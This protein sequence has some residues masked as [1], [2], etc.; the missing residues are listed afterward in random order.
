MDIY[1]LSDLVFVG[2]S[3]VATG[4][5][6]LLEPASLGL[7]SLFGPFMTNFREIAALTLQYGAGVQVGNEGELLEAARDFLASAELRQ[8]IGK[9]GLKMV[10]DNSGATQRYMGLIARALKQ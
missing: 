2:G 7:P 4:G 9:N 5:H 10:R 8:V 1:A 6:N 3:L